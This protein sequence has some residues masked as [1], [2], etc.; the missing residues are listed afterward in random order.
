[1]HVSRNLDRTA[2]SA[3][4]PTVMLRSDRR[5]L[6]FLFLV[7]L[8]A[9]LG[10]GACSKSGS[11]TSPYG[12]G[13]G[14]GTGTPFN[15]GPFGL[16]QSA[17]LTFANAGTFGYHCIPHQGMGMTGSVQVE[18]GGPDSAVVQIAASGLTFTPTTAHIRP[19]GHMRWVNASASTVHTVTSD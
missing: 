8:L 7:A 12:G 5:R 3:T 2:R 16:N 17:A 6:Q 14:G 18:V 13:G 9:V 10:A 19:G 15:L 1:M 4:T 11:P